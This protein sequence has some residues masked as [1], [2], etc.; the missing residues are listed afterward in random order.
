VRGFPFA[1]AHKQN[2][3]ARRAAPIDAARRLAIDEAAIL[4]EIFA[5]PA[6]RRPCTP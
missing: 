2:I 1:L 3:V 6:R 4:P 5:G